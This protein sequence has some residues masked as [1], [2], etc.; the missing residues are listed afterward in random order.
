MVNTCLKPTTPERKFRAKRLMEVI[1]DL[2]SMSNTAS[3]G[4]RIPQGVREEADDEGELEQPL[5][6]L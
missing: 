3:S 2:R 4:T 1:G 5:T 6:R